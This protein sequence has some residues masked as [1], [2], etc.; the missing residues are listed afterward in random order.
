MKHKE[1][2]LHLFPHLNKTV[3]KRMA[4][5]IQCI[6]PWNWIWRGLRCSPG[7]SYK[8]AIHRSTNIKSRK[9][10]SCQVP[11]ALDLQKFSLVKIKCFNSL[12]YWHRKKNMQ[13]MKFGHPI[14]GLRTGIS[15]KYQI[16]FSPQHWVL[17]GRCGTAIGFK[18]K[19]EYPI[20]IKNDQYAI[21]NRVCNT[22]WND[23]KEAYMV[24]T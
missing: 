14:L 12:Q 8:F 5:N 16:S 23:F 13:M 3:S 1:E 6:H 2:L 15:A 19:Q 22:R 10:S 18:L 7:S 11:G 17:V 9:L 21:P 24:V 4:S 20:S